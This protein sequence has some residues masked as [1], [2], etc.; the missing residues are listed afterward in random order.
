MDTPEMHIYIWTHG[1]IMTTGTYPKLGGSNKNDKAAQQKR[2]R[3]D[4][5]VFVPSNEFYDSVTCV[6]FLE[7]NHHNLFNV[8]GDRV[9]SSQNFGSQSNDSH[10]K[11]NQ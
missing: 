7:L 2:A 1:K 5:E 11:R 3:Y 9:D 4:R 8:G 10:E 6:V